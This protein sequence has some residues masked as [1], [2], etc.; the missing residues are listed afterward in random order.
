MSNIYQS[1]GRQY[2]AQESLENAVKGK[3][4]IAKYLLARCYVENS[5]ENPTE[6]R[7][8]IPLLEKYIQE[9]SKQADE[10]GNMYF[11]HSKQLLQTLREMKD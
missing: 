4:L 10:T 5:N 9:A 1:M 2:R 6:M 11:N 7:R 3:I 8:A